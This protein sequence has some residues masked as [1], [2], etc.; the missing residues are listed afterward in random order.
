MKLRFAVAAAI[1]L[2]LS[3]TSAPA[4]M[5]ILSESDV[6]SNVTQDNLIYYHMRAG[7]VEAGYQVH[8]LI[9]RLP[10]AEEGR[11]VIYQVIETDHGFDAT[12]VLADLYNDPEV[13]L[14]RDRPMIL[15]QF[16]AYHSVQEIAEEALEDFLV[17][18]EEEKALAE[19]EDA[20]Q[21]AP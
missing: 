10:E 13:G 9:E 18:L 17:R 6:G 7:L 5:I 11:E 14:I 1:G 12:F 16:H 21:E 8:W 20:E 2:A 15:Y 4:Q 3:A 19:A